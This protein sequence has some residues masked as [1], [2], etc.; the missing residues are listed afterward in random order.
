MISNQYLIE[1]ICKKNSIREYLAEKNIFPVNQSDTRLS[2]LCPLHEDSHPSFV[3]YFSEEKNE[4]YYCYGCH[5]G[6]NL[7]SLYSAM[8]GISWR[9]AI[10]ILGKGMDLSD[11]HKLNW[12]IETLKK[13]ANQVLPDNGKNHFGEIS[14]LISVMGN[15][16]M[17]RT[18]FDEDEI[19]FL[20][21][22]YNK[23][24]QCVLEW[25]L[26]KLERI[27]DFVSGNNK[28]GKN[29]FEHR[30]NLWGKKKKEEFRKETIHHD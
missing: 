17:K 15:T 27:Y 24:D 10:K 25:D 13:E 9:E 23:I 3:V 1:N 14:L 19:M 7:I 26:I 4:N 30:M 29:L 21:K 28:Y 11:P 6:G 8:E 5:F 12:I 2:Y 16:H 22:F 20:D 18:D